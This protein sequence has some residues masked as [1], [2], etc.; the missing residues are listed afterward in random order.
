MGMA[1]EASLDAIADLSARLARIET[2][3]DT[4]ETR[5]DTIFAEL[6]RS[7]CTNPGGT[8]WT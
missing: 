1:P 8:T 5:L 3:L 4:I 2:R 6:T 7:R